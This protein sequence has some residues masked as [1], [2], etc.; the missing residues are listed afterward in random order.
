MKSSISSKLQW[1]F[2]GL[3]EGILPDSMRRLFS[4]SWTREAQHLPKEYT[5]NPPGSPGGHVS[6]DTCLTNQLA[7]DVVLLAEYGSGINGDS[8]ASEVEQDVL[9]LSN[10]HGR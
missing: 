10:R 4:D 5:K 7:V 3:C 2:A 6:A 8:L 1:S 9:P